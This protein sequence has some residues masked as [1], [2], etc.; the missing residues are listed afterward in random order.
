MDEQNDSINQYIAVWHDGCIRPPRVFI[1]WVF[2][3]KTEKRGYR[4]MK[5]LGV[6][7]AALVLLVAAEAPSWGDAF[8]DPATLHIGTGFGTPCAKGCGGDPN[9]ISST[10][11]SIYLNE[12]N[13]NLLLSNPLILIIGVPDYVSVSGAGTTAPTLSGVTFYD[14]L[15]SGTPG[16]GVGFAAL[17]FGQNGG[18]GIMTA[19]N[20]DGQ[21]YVQ[22]KFNHS[23]NDSNSWVNW[24]ALDPGVLA[25]DLYAFRLNQSI[26]GG[27]LL[28]LTGTLAAGSFVI[29]YG[30]NGD[31]LDSTDGACAGGTGKTFSTPFTEAGHNTGVPEPATLLLLGSGLAGVGLWARRKFGK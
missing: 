2:S 3:E 25:F 22:A 4:T 12:Q 7:A 24:S 28:D 9:I 5:R 31:N 6:V 10:N 20:G 1:T 14:D 13:P 26:G 30:C 17:T 11:F 27:D 29:A 19:A 15:G 21:A 16:T 18:D 8:T 23:T